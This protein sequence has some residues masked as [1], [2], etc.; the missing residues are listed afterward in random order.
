[1][2]SSINTSPLL[3]QFKPKFLLKPVKPFFCNCKHPS[4]LVIPQKK[5]SNKQGTERQFQLIIIKYYANTASVDLSAGRSD[6][7]ITNIGAGFC[8]MVKRV[9]S[10]NCEQQHCLT[11]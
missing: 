7:H 1:M 8:S 2:S 10:R 11:V 5:Q 4:G 3:I 9:R 6:L